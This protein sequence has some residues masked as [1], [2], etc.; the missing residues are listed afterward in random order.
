MLPCLDRDHKPQTCILQALI[1][2]V[3][4]HSPALTTALGTYRWVRGISA[5]AVVNL[6]WFFCFVVQ[7]KI[8]RFVGKIAILP[9]P[10]LISSH[11]L[12][13]LL[14]L[15]KAAR[16]PKGSELRLCKHQSVLGFPAEMDVIIQ[17]SPYTKI[18]DVPREIWLHR[19]KASASLLGK[20]PGFSKG[21]CSAQ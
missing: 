12:Q 19:P 6:R 1:H 21:A 18:L 2:L 8:H 17:M 5:Y 16:K 3:S 11:P 7:F 10:W 14:R 15:Q 4:P 20:G 13:V 9:L